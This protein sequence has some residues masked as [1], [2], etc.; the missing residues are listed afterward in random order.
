MAKHGREVSTRSALEQCL[1]SGEGP[2]VG[3]PCRT[4]MRHLGEDRTPGLWAQWGSCE[5]RVGGGQRSHSPEE[6]A[7]RERMQ[8][9]SKDFHMPT[10]GSLA[11]G[12]QLAIFTE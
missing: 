1:R 8:S 3:A 11:W 10:P 7:D 5:G 12:R 4:A 6:A 9:G 2:C